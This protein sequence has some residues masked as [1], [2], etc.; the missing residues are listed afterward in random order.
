[1]IPSKKLS[2]LSPAALDLYK[3]A[4]NHGISHSLDR[5]DVLAMA[6]ATEIAEAGLGRLSVF[7]QSANLYPTRLAKGFTVARNEDPSDHGLYIEIEVLRNPTARDGYLLACLYGA[8]F[9][10]NTSTG[11]P[12]PTWQ[13]KVH[14]ASARDCDH[15]RSILASIE[16]DHPVIDSHDGRSTVFIGRLAE[17]LMWPTGTDI[18]LIDA[19][20][21]SGTDVLAEP[22]MCDY[23]SCADNPHPYGPYLPEHREDIDAHKGRA[24]RITSTPVALVHDNGLMTTDAGMTNP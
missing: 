16:I 5:S 6:A 19:H 12:W 3:R 24:V 18:T 22:A 7:E 9:T 2:D 4:V 11:A 8:T 20:S 23:G 1:M 17:A 15:S 21:G 13:A 14:H 10:S